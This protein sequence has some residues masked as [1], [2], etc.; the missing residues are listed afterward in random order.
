MRGTR[1]VKDGVCSYVG[2][3]PAYAGNTGLR[4][5]VCALPRDHPRICGEHRI[6]CLRIVVIWGSSP[7]MRGTPCCCEMSGHE[8]GII[9]AYAGNTYVFPQ[10]RTSPR[11]HPRI[12]GEH[13]LSSKFCCVT[14]GSSPHMRG[15]PHFRRSA[16]CWR[17]IIP[18]Y[19]GN[20]DGVFYVPGAVWDHPRICGEHFN[21]RGD[22]IIVTGSS[23]H[24][25]G[26][27]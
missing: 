23:P 3:I 4:G 18:A 14:L 11:D 26:T 7:H 16:P 19:A 8:S 6:M 13:A 9:P 21:M 25:R 12:C 20:T 24:M 17:G 2:I 15:T 22:D 10:L 1:G 27:H 5:L